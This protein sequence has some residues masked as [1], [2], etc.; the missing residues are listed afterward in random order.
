[1][2]AAA[3]EAEAAAAEA[4]AAEAAAADAAT[5]AATDAAVGP[6][7]RRRSSVREALR[8]FVWASPKKATRGSI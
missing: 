8:R 1:M 3:R 5:D 7:P 2:A 4:A 6:S